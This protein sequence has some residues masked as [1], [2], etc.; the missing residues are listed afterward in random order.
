MK[1]ILKLFPIL[2]ILFSVNGCRGYATDR[3]INFPNTK[4][5]SSNPDIYFQVDADSQAKGEIKINGDIIKIE[6]LFGQATSVRF[7]IGENTP[8]SP[9]K[10]V[11][12]VEGT[13]SKNKMIVKV[14]ED[15]L[16][17]NKHKELVFNKE[18]KK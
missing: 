5:V 3:P 1:K 2:F 4:W 14:L 9:L 6:L 18:V 10:P 13:F 17:N 8:S 7:Y 12:D 16:F 11:L 15:K